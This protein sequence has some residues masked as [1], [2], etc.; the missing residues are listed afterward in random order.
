MTDLDLATFIKREGLWGWIRDFGHYS[1]LNK[2]PPEVL[3]SQLS[4][5]YGDRTMLAKLEVKNA[6]DVAYIIFVNFDEKW[7]N[8]IKV[9]SESFNLAASVSNKKTENTTTTEKT[10]KEAANTNKVSAFNSDELI[11]DGGS[12]QTESGDKDGTALKITTDDKISLDSAF[13]NLTLADQISIIKTVNKD[14]AQ[15]LTLSIY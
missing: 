7:Q 2:Y 14:I 1:F 5:L 12:D 4:L 3:D 15:F 11:V 13:N 9:N 10:A 6:Y 8:L